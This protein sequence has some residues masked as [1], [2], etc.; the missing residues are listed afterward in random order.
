MFVNDIKHLT[1]MRIKTTIIINLFCVIAVVAQQGNHSFN[2]YNF[3]YLTI[4][5]GLSDN[6]VHAIH[7]DYNSFM[8]FGTSYGLERFDGYEFKH[9]SANSDSPNLFIESS[10]IHDIKEDKYHNLWIASDAGIFR[11]DLQ[12][13]NIIFFKNLFDIFIDCFFHRNRQQ[14]FCR[15]INEG[16]III[17]VGSYNPFRCT[18]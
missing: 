6:S 16:Y 12:R 17:S 5:N 14:F 1:K 10:Y 11:I 15:R 3:S 8:W 4:D 18:I 13:E 9:Y 2:E 7:K